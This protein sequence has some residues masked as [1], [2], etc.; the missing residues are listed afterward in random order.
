MNLQLYKKEGRWR[1]S[2][3][4]RNRGGEKESFF[5]FLTE[6]QLINIE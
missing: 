2:D 6:C 3:T 1:G 4:E 5:F